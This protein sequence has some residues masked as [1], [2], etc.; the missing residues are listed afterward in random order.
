MSKNQ[1]LKF[2]S[3]LRFDLAS[4]DWV[5]IATGRARRPETFKKERRKIEKVS[6]KDCPFC[7][8]HTQE[9]PTILF[10]NG[11]KIKFKPGSKIPKNWTTISVPNKYPAFIPN[12]KIDK[13]IEGGLY[14]KM[15]AVG[16]HEVVI[17]RDHNKQMTQFS[18]KQIK[19]V[20]DIYQERYLSL[21]K[22]K[23]V[24]YIS[25]FHNH[26]IESGA[27][28]AHPHSQIITT[29]LIDTDLKKAIRNSKKY[30]RAHKKCL[31][32]LM[33]DW[34]RKNKKRVVFENND[35]LVICPFAS[36]MA[37]EVIIT[38]KKHLSYFERITEKEKQHLAE[39][40]QKALSKLYKGLNDP[41]YNFYLHT[42]PCDGRNY[43]HY[44]WHWT[45]L[46]KTSTWAGFEIGTR[47]EISTI[48]P[49]KAA[50]YLRKQ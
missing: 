3:E 8:I 49:E 19:E 43:D 37:F 26:G 38:P 41:A 1:K 33:G 40:F 45:I 32:C 47:M 11:K 20:I 10:S 2:P 22:E 34:E 48:E 35:F 23:F 44:H 31:Y 12:S 9:M 21:M 39:A 16:F 42:A 27:S 14:E 13:H 5:V 7:Q 4:K 50:E 15:N 30:F 46:P 24:N 6:K 18:I 28:I 36:K 29:P 25:I 17:T